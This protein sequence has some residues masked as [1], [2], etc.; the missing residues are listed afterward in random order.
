MEKP[1]EITVCEDG[2]DIAYQKEVMLDT[3]REFQLHHWT[4]RI[5]SNPSSPYTTMH[6]IHQ[7]SIVNTHQQHPK[8]CTCIDRLRSRRCSSKRKYHYKGNY[9]H[10]DACHH[11]IVRVM[12][13]DC[14]YERADGDGGLTDVLLFL[15]NSLPLIV[16]MLYRRGIYFTRGGY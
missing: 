7:T 9:H 2:I 14:V 11:P 12:V 5:D 3:E 13:R 8:S 4:Q 15:S 16:C 6:C 10:D 1:N